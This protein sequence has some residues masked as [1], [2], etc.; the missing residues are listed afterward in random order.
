MATHARVVGKSHAVGI[1][2]TMTMI[3]RSTPGPSTPAATELPAPIGASHL[4]TGPEPNG[5]DRYAEIEAMIAAAKASGTHYLIPTW[6]GWSVRCRA[7]GCYAGGNSPHLTP[8]Y[9]LA[10]FHGRHVPC[11]FPQDNP[12]RAVT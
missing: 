3:G 5:G 11:K 7:C 4:P 12:F 6:P 9:A 8:E 10:H 1:W 2:A